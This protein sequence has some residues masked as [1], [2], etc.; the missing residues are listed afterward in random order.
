MKLKKKPP[1][2]VNVSSRVDVGK[3]QRVIRSGWPI[4]Q[5]SYQVN[6]WKYYETFL[7]KN[8]YV[9]KA[10][11]ARSVLCQRG[12]NYMLHAVCYVA[13]LYEISYVEGV[14]RNKK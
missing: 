11:F 4:M 1:K 3:D 9:E 6:D 13:R 12:R 8:W 5:M 10:S 14:K 7:T 2:W